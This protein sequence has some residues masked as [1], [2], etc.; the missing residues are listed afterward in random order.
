MINT[1]NVYNMLSYS[2]S[3]LN[4]EGFSNVGNRNLQ[5]VGD[6]FAQVIAKGLQKQAAHG[7]D[8][9]YE[10][11]TDKLTEIRGNIN[12]NES[13]RQFSLQEKKLV[14]DFDEY[15]SNSYLN[16]VLKTVILKLAT[17]EHVSGDSRKLLQQGLLQ[18]EDVSLITTG[19]IS[20]SKIAYTKN[21]KNYKMLMDIC[22]L[23]DQGLTRDS[24]NKLTQFLSDA[25]VEHLFSQFVFE[26]ITRH[27]F[28]L[29]IIVPSGIGGE[30]GQRTQ[31][32]NQLVQ[33]MSEPIRYIICSSGEMTVI[34]GIKYIPEVKRGEHREFTTSELAQRYQQTLT[35]EVESVV[36][37]I[38]KEA[39][40]EALASKTIRARLIVG[41]ATNEEL[42]LVQTRKNRI[43]VESLP[44][45]MQNG[46]GSINRELK[47]LVTSDFRAAVRFHD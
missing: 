12:V 1:R 38:Y 46:W 8:K 40:K 11:Q 24:N 30:V 10:R 28:G 34:Y 44:V 31:S 26:W 7:L 16:Q 22:Y 6:L 27:V 41:Y 14:C 42:T 21:N 45:N 19:N 2:F 20:W 5:G 47:K 25:R 35:D 4:E 23:V 39:S 37:G 15:T 36:E 18:L 17:S 9:C 3:I 13:I 33:T 32:S 43:R 29:K